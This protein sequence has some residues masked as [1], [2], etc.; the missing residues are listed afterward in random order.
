[1]TQANSAIP[2]TK[3]SAMNRVTATTVE[4]ERKASAMT[5]VLKVRKN[6]KHNMRYDAAMKNVDCNQVYIS[7][8][9]LE[10][11]FGGYP[12]KVSLIVVVEE[13]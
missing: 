5:Q 9:W 12:R 13:M 2:F 4:G 7:K 8:E 11:H 3:R 1:M 6:C 10:A